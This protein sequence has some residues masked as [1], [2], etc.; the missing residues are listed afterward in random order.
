VD[1]V[2]LLEKIARAA[3]DYQMEA[4]EARRVVE[5]REEASLKFCT[6]LLAV[7]RV[8]LD[9]KKGLRCCSLTTSPTKPS[10]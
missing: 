7:T 5:R 6:R 3:E 8:V 4:T 2:S 10:S 9:E 1:L